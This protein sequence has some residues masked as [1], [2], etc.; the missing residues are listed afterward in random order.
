MMREALSAGAR[1]YIVK[2]DA[3]R[4]LLAALE[5]VSQHRP[6]IAQNRGQVAILTKRTLR[7]DLWGEQDAQVRF[8]E[9]GRDRHDFHLE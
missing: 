7:P 8:D 9:P 3:A 5:A 6:F 2:S 1:G 4:D